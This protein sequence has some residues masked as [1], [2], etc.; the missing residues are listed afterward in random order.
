MDSTEFDELYSGECDTSWVVNKRLDVAYGPHERN[1]YDVYYPDGKAPEE[2]WPLIVFFHGGAFMKGD[3]RRYQ[4]RPALV[5][6]RR[7]Y[8]VASV[9]Y[10]LVTTDPL[11]AAFADA[12]NALR[13]VAA[14]A[15]E[16][17]IDAR[18][19]VLWGESVGAELACFAGLVDACEFVDDPEAS[20]MPPV[21]GVVDWYAPLDLLAW[22]RQLTAEG[23]FVL[24]DGRSALEQLLAA[25]GEDFIA[26]AALLDP[27]NYLHAGICPVLV[28]HGMADPLVSPR[29]SQAFH[30]NLLA[31]LPEE[32]MP[33]RLVEGAVHGVASFE[34][35]DNL[36][37]V[38]A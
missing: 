36:D 15:D 28:E 26:K 3:K 13:H 20:P 23:Q 9:Q 37:W 7:G 32:D 17:G 34:N 18:R 31:F 4:M 30:E 11:P 25:S 8:A 22:R 1:C 6:V 38:C 12:R 27:N 2:G 21:R 10:R 16:L 35:D 29:Q 19:I 14:H 33:F 24:P 5:G